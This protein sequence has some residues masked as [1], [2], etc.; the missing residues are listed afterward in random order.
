[1]RHLQLILLI[2][3]LGLQAVAGQE[4]VTDL[5]GLHQLLSPG[6]RA[7]KL[8][9]TV[10]KYQESQTPRVPD[11][12]GMQRE[13]PLDFRETGEFISVELEPAATLKLSTTYTDSSVTIKAL[14]NT[15][16]P[17]IS[18]NLK[19]HV[20]LIKD[21]HLKSVEK[22]SVESKS[23]LFQSAWHGYQWQA[24]TKERNTLSQHRITIGKLEENGA[25][26]LEIVWLE[27]GQRFHYRLL[28]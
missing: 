25:V 17:T 5:D 13:L 20:A 3:L 6:D 14:E 12:N 18:I 28:G 19:T 16:C 11:E 24:E 1:M 7:F 23:N 10:T 8:M 15:F 27:G 21:Q 9:K 2:F 22:I 4:P 26:Y